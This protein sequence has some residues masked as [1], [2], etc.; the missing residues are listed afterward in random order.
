M[1]EIAC[2][3]LRNHISAS[4]SFRSLSERHSSMHGSFPLLLTAASRMWVR[5]C[6]FLSV[7]LLLLLARADRIRPRALFSGRHRKCLLLLVIKDFYAFFLVSSCYCLLCCCCCR[8]RYSPKFCT[9]APT[10]FF[11][12]VGASSSFNGN[13]AR[14]AGLLRAFLIHHSFF[15]FFTFVRVCS[16][17]AFHADMRP[18]YPPG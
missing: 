9:H 4:Q 6:D 5:A 10:P 13:L 14:P 8:R 1:H 11:P 12:F 15:F 16:I 7:F 17:A 18:F 3:F 2:M